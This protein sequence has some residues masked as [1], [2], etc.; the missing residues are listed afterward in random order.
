MIQLENLVHT[1]P[2][3]K[4]DTVQSEKTVLNG[5]SLHV[6]QGQF[7]AILGPNGCGKSTLAKHL[8]A[9]LLPKS[10]TV[11]IDGKK[12]SNIETLWDIRRQVGMV[13]QNPDNQIIGTTVE[14]DTAFALENQN[15]PSGFIQQKVMQSLKSV[16]LFHKRKTAPNR[17]SGGQKQRVAIAGTIAAQVRCIVLDEP[18]AMLDPAA[19]RDVME[20]VHRLNKEQGITVVLIT[21]H[22]DEVADAD[23]ILL[24]KEGTIFKQGT[25]QEIFSHPQWLREV[26]MDIPQGTLLAERLRQRGFPLT[27]PMLHEEVLIDELNKMLPHHGANSLEEG[28]ATKTS[29]DPILQ[30]KNICCT[31]HA[32]TA[33]E[34]KVLKEIT[35]DIYPGEWLGIVG[36]SGCGKTTLIKHLNGLLKASAGDILFE[37]NS[38][39][40]K[41]FRLSALRKE[42]GLVFQYPEHQLFGSTVLKDVCYGPLNMKMST[43]QAERSAR[44]S[45]QLVGIKEESYYSNPLDLSGGEKRRVAIAGILA[46]NPKVLILDEPAAGLDPETKQMIFSLLTKIKKERDLSIV[47][48]SHHMEDIAEYADRMIVLRDGK[49]EDQGTPKEVFSHSKALCEM[50]IGIPQI[51]RITKALIEKGV[52]LSHPAITV[53]EAEQMIV[54]FAGEG[55]LR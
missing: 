18:T 47:V 14:E 36:T 21:H 48:V 6:P 37:G 39:Y 33:N 41:K 29:G 35:F 2:V 28:A 34:N 53:D 38:I 11:W 7:L 4:S 3:W 9:L 55:A 25:P 8:N 10:G 15:L 16:N 5:I 20:L 27:T 54:S 32:K 50:G 17:L 19:R 24:M 44:E 49:I 40:H 22:T 1:Y 31:Y 46:M 12:T 45:L 30:I 42:V 52:P 13:F 43:E 51:T 23:S 26:K